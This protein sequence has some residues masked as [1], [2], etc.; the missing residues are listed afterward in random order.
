LAWLHWI[1]HPEIILKKICGR[2]AD[3]IADA[4]VPAEA[5]A[6]AGAVEVA[7]GAVAAAISQPI[8]QPV[9]FF[10]TDSPIGS[11]LLQ[12]GFFLALCDFTA[13]RP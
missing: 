3:P 10:A 7:A 6:A 12:A 13:R 11:H 5:V 4:A 9:S 2:P 8:F 1:T